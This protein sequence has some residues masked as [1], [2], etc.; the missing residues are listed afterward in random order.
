M[1]DFLVFAFFRIPTSY[2]RYHFST[3]RLLTGAGIR[4]P[5]VRE[6]SKEEKSAKYKNREAEICILLQRG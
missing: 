1:A 3:V 5:T 4:V 6:T 2:I